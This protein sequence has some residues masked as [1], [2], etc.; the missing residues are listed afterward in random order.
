MVYY[1]LYA[2]NYV[3]IAD[4]PQTYFKGVSERVERERGNE[5]ML[6]WEKFDEW[7]ISERSKTQIKLLEGIK[8]QLTR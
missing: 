5:S 3:K 7:T 2:I 6:K 8:N 4:D 1:Q